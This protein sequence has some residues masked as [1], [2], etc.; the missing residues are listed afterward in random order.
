VCGELDGLRWRVLFKHDWFWRDIFD[1]LRDPNTPFVDPI[2][3]RDLITSGQAA[4]S[5]GDGEGLREAVRGLW[6]L[7]PKGNAD[8]TRERAVRSGLR[9]Y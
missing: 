2:A 4:I 7:Q 5:G 1:S 9:K 6:K 8:A 3:A